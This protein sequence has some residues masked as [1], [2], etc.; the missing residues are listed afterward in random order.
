MDT[1]KFPFN[2]FTFLKEKVSA[3]V[4]GKPL[5]AEKKPDDAE[6]QGKA[7]GADKE[8]LPG[9]RN[10]WGADNNPGKHNGAS[11]DNFVSN[12]YPGEDVRLMDYW[13]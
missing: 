11:K 9:N 5:K 3:I 13:R 4:H 12:D 6:S 2:V 8:N 10:A 1:S 7:L